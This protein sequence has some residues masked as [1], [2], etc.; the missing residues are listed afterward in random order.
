LTEGL[1]LSLTACGAGMALAWFGLNGL[2]SLESGPESVY[3]ALTL[4]WRV[5]AGALLV[6]ALSPLAFAV[7]P[8]LDAFRNQGLH[9]HDGRLGDRR[10]TRPARYGLVALQVGLTVVL[11]I[12]VGAF[13][14]TAWALM[15]TPTGFDASHLLTFRVELSS[16]RYSDAAVRTRFVQDLLERLS[17][18]AGVT[19]A[20][21]I[22]RLP[23]AD[24][25]ESARLSIAG[26]DRRPE[27]EPA[28]AVARITENYLDAMRIP[29]KAGRPLERADVQRARPVALI[30]ETAARR[31]W[32]GRNPIG[33][34]MAIVPGDAREWLEV[35]GV[36]GDVRNSDADQGPAAQVYIP[37]SLATDAALAVVLRTTT[38]PAAMA[39]TVR[40]TVGQF[41]A[42]LPVF[43]LRTMD[44][45]IFGDTAGTVLVMSIL[46]T[47]AFVAVCV[48]AAGIYGL[49]AFAVTQRTKEMGVRLA[50]GARPAAV[51]RLIVAQT[52]RP[53][54][55]GATLGATAA[56]LLAPFASAAIAEVDF[57]NPVDFAAVLIGLGVVSLA[58]TCL[59]AR[60]V[61][62][63]DP[64]VALRVD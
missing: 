8:A 48:A 12:Q 53:V 23:I 21:A 17:Q 59:P 3:S 32:P 25:E 10:S 26:V 40:E 50:L 57:R 18:S 44:A 5:L 51:W 46:T 15:S 62:R 7:L 49:T 63:I 37:I 56:L 16:S 45:V 24:R 34:R 4:N 52:G 58:A 38:D 27:D 61:T 13:A 30:S 47:V 39:G 64:A 54:A 41:D 1:L 35:V 6:A 14:R 43:G 28:I 29:L 42:A 36:A 33:Q 19:A 55:A 9:R 60:R 31:F 11:L 20:A 2:R 22:N